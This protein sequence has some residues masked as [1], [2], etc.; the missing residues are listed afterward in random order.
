MRT[1]A[2]GL[3]F[4]AVVWAQSGLTAP[5]VGCYRDGAGAARPLYG[6]A[7]SFIPAPAISA[8]TLSAACSETAALL[9]S[10]DAVEW[11]G[12]SFELVSRWPAPEGPALFAFAGTRTALAYFRSSRKMIRF[13]PRRL[14]RTMLL[15]EP[16]RTGEVLGIAAPDAARASAL[17]RDATGISVITWTVADGAE[18]ARTDADGQALLQPDGTVIP[19][20]QI[21]GTI[22]AMQPLGGGWIAVSL[23]RGGN[24]LAVRLTAG[25]PEVFR[26]PEAVK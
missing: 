25:R 26:I 5:R 15:P 2:A 7:G 21:A 4:A 12:G 18:T 24:P 3:V 6:V 11:R 10:S 13:E 19:A 20:P 23:E 16:L 14:P 9:K 8:G 17:I 1:M 22:D